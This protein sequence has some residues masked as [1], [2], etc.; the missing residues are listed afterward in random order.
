MTREPIWTLPPDP[1]SDE[2]EELARL[3]NVPF[4][5]ARLL[6]KRGIADREGGERFLRPGLEH[7]VDPFRL[8]GM[9]AATERILRALE[10]GERIGVFGDFDVDGV[11][12]AALLF[13]VFRRLGSPPVCRLPHRLQEGYGLSRA[14][15]DDIAERGVRLLITVDSGVTGHAAIDYAGGLGM[16]CIVTDHHEPKESLPNALA[17]ID[18]KRE[19]CRYPHPDLVGVGLAWKLADALASRGAGE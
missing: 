16:E 19:D 8:A 14:A 9:E 12:S 13:R 3:W 7:L 10:G 17:V 2:I 11:T 6:R 18:P 4:L 5:V 15:V 1:P